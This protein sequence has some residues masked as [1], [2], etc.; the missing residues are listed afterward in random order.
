MDAGFLYQLS[1]LHG[2]LPAGTR[3]KRMQASVFSLVEAGVCFA[4]NQVQFPLLEKS[5]S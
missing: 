4:Q 2:S 1:L 3:R 5:L